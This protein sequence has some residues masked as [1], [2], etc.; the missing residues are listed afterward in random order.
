MKTKKLIFLFL[1]GFGLF[2]LASCNK[3][4]DTSID[5]KDAETRASVD[6]DDWFPEK[7][8]FCKYYHAYSPSEDNYY[9]V[10]IEKDTNQAKLK[11]VFNGKETIYD[12]KFVSKYHFADNNNSVYYCDGYVFYD[13]YWTKDRS[14]YN[15]IYTSEA[16]QPKKRTPESTPAP[17][18]SS[19]S[20]SSSSENR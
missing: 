11:F 19:V 2:S 4:T 16:P 1:V 7:S 18:S 8:V 13:L 15:D 3:Q 20:P 14:M 12:I 9:E 10:Y 5:P 17:S 6:T